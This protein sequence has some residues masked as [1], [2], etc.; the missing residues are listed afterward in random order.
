MS[1]PSA[2]RANRP[3]W[4]RRR[5]RRE[6][7]G[8]LPQ[9]DAVRPGRLL[10]RPRGL[11]RTAAG[12]P[13]GAARAKLRVVSREPGIMS[14]VRLVVVGAAGR[15]GRMLIAAIGDS[16]GVDARPA[17][18]NRPPRPSSVR[19][20]ACWSGARPMGW[21]SPPIPRRVLSQADALIDFSSPATT[22]ALA[23]AG[24]AGRRR[25]CH[26]HHRPLAR[27]TSPPSPRPPSAPSS[28]APA[29]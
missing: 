22:V 9:G 8:T 5:R 11:Y 29:I 7:R 4:R 15:M 6:R 20:P 14:E 18:S 24:G 13:L 26:R 23:G 21:L 16:L 17:R 19:T 12:P 10:I 28:C 1:S 2:P 3:G 27:R 25:A